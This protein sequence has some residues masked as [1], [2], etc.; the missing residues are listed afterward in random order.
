MATE[1]EHAETM[2]RRSTQA[3]KPGKFDGTTS[4]DTFLVQFSTVVGYNRWSE[5]NRCAQL[6]CCLSGTAVQLLWE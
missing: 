5:R 4:I 6:K 3:M 2:T 1:N